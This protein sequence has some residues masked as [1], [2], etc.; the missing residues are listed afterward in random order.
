MPIFNILRPVNG[1]V[2]DPLSLLMQPPEDESA[3]E[4]EARFAAEAEAQLRSNAIDEEI[5]R[6][7]Q[8]LKKA[9]KPVR[10]LLLGAL[11]I[12]TYFF[13]HNV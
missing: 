12:Y 8:E 13:L 4:R 3:E 2:D 5:S 6:Q 10:V 9:P 11:S 1:S 7:R